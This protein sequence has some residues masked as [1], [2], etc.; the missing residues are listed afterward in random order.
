M[1]IT[2]EREIDGLRGELERLAEELDRAKEEARQAR[3]D[4]KAHHK[5]NSNE[6][7]LSSLH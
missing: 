7:L 2:Q 1:I 3:L 6:A 5:L 4:V